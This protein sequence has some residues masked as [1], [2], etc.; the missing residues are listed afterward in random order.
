MLK[1]CRNCGRVY[2]PHSLPVDDAL[3]YL[4]PMVLEIGSIRHTQ[5]RSKSLMIFMPLSCLGMPTLIETSLGLKKRPRT[6]QEERSP[7]NWNA[8]SICRAKQYSTALISPECSKGRMIQNIELVMIE[9]FGYG[10]A[11]RTAA[12]T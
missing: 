11:L 4:H 10:S 8:T 2:I 1:V 6:C 7:K 5:R 3:P 9:I 12:V